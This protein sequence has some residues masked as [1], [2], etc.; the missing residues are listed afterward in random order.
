MLIMF[1]NMIVPQGAQRLE[2]VR[3]GL[4]PSTLRGVAQA[5]GPDRCEQDD[6]LGGDGPRRPKQLD[7]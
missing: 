6:R 5:E 4:R 3:V 1:A 7:V 2:D